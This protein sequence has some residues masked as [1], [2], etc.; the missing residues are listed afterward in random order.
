MRPA[1]LT[2]VMSSVVQP[3]VEMIDVRPGMEPP[4]GKTPTVR[5]PLVRAVGMTTESGLTA[6]KAR[7]SGVIGPT[8][9]E[10]L[11]ARTAETSSRPSLVTESMSPG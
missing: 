3:S 11:V 1:S 7:T 2:K 6:T 8:S 5:M 10:S 4:V 9:L